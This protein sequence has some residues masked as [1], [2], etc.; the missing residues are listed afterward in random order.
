MINFVIFFKSV[1]IKEFE[2]TLVISTYLG[3]FALGC[4]GGVVLYETSR[5]GC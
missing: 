4:D 3:V 5:D 2:E 1:E